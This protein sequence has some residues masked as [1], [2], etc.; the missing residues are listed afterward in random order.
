MN[1]LALKEKKELKI[2]LE[3]AIRISAL[4]ME[5]FFLDVFTL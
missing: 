3:P 1:I 4:E 5:T 2:E